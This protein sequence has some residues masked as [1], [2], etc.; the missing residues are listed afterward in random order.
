MIRNI[1]IIAQHTIDVNRLLIS[2]KI[3][4][5]TEKMKSSTQFI[6]QHVIQKTSEMCYN[7]FW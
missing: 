6:N 1:S 3:L 5:S 4:G 7:L 2:E